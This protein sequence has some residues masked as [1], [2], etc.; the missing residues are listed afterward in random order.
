MPK[1]MSHV[2]RAAVAAETSGPLVFETSSAV[3]ALSHCSCY[4]IKVHHGR[5]GGRYLCWY[6]PTPNAPQQ[7]FAM[8]MTLD[9][10]M[11]DA[12]HHA[13]TGQVLA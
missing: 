5:K 9:E 8:R 3:A 2:E 4:Q 11:A 1:T 12:Q 6:L 7:L 13:R 10:A